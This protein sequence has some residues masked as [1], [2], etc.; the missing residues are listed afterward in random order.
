MP[1][2]CLWVQGYRWATLNRENF[3]SNTCCAQRALCVWSGPAWQLE[4]KY[5]KWASLN[6]LWPSV[7]HCCM[8]EILLRGVSCD[9]AIKQTWPQRQGTECTACWC[10]FLCITMGMSL[11][12]MVNFNRNQERRKMSGSWKHLIR[13]RYLLIFWGLFSAIKARAG[14]RNLQENR[15]SW[16]KALARVADPKPK[17]CCDQYADFL[18][19]SLLADIKYSDL[20]KKSKQHRIVMS[21][22]TTLSTIRIDQRLGHVIRM[23]CYSSWVI[24]SQVNSFALV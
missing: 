6:Y 5:S 17:L 11:D 16:W 7:C 3:P 14:Q 13:C 18:C 12:Q 20:H 8:V 19:M 4:I 9:D 10:V 1:V 2:I 24:R 15:P 22:C 23:N 21:D